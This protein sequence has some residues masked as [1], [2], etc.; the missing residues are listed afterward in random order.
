MW[1]ALP[2][3]KALVTFCRMN[4]TIPEVLWRGFYPSRSFQRFCLFQVRS[5]GWFSFCSVKEIQ[6]KTTRAQKLDSGENV[7]ES[8]ARRSLRTASGDRCDES[9]IFFLPPTSTVTGWRVAKEQVMEAGTSAAWTRSG[10]DAERQCSH[11]AILPW[12]YENSNYCICF[13]ISN[14]AR[15]LF[16]LGVLRSWLPKQIINNA[17]MKV[18][19]GQ[20]AGW[21][22]GGEK[23]GLRKGMW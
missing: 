16:V 11:I 15:P 4:K 12:K 3:N 17:A 21:V 9:R 8:S 19:T 2:L 5:R 23:A 1:P 6:V 10:N 20:L 13:F 14:V 22:A 7:R 18:S